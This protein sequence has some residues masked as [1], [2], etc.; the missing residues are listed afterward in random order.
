MPE[1]RGARPQRQ[2]KLEA[3]ARIAQQQ[4]NQG[5]LGTTKPEGNTNNNNTAAKKVQD[6]VRTKR[7]LENPKDAAPVKDVE[8]VDGN[9][10]NDPNKENAVKLNP[11]ALK[12]QPVGRQPLAAPAAAPAAPAAQPVK[13]AAPVQPAAK[14]A[15]D[16]A[17]EGP[18][19][20]PPPAKVHIPIAQQCVYGRVGDVLGHIAMNIDK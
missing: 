18:D 19:A 9:K 17:D 4:T 1:V 3:A 13:P 2:A 20:H 14:P 16:A 15:A 6:T 8:K 10:P 12:G 11:P 5:Q 7:E